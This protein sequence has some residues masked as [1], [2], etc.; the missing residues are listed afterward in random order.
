M[1]HRWDLSRGESH[2]VSWPGNPGAE[3]SGRL[4]FGTVR[5]LLFYHCAEQLTCW[6]AADDWKRQTFVAEKAGRP[7]VNPVNGRVAFCARGMLHLRDGRTLEPVRPPYRITDKKIT[8]IPDGQT[9][10]AIGASGRGYVAWLY[11]ADSG[12]TSQPLT[13]PGGEQNADTDEIITELACSPDGALLASASEWSRHVKLWDLAGYRLAADRI[14]GTSG[15]MRLAFRP[16]GHTLAVAADRTVSLFEVTG[17]DVHTALALQP[18]PVHT[19]AVGPDG[20]SLVCLATAVPERPYSNVTW[21]P[22]GLN[23]AAP[24]RSHS[25]NRVGGHRP[26]AA[27]DP[28]GRGIVY[29]TERGDA[30][31]VEFWAARG[32]PHF[33]FQPLD[34]VKQVRFG[35]DGSL[36]AAAGHEVLA[37]ALP[38]WRALARWANGPADR[39][40]GLVYCTVAPGRVWVLAGRRDGRV[41]LLDPAA[42]HHATWTVG[43]MLVS[44]LALDE[45]AGLAVAG[46]ES[47]LVK[48]FRVPSGEVAADIPLAHRDAVEAA[49][50][51]PGGQLFATGGRDRTI[52]LWQADGKPVL[53]F[54]A[55]AP[56]TML[57]FTPDGQ[58]LIALAAGERG[59]RRWRLGRLAERL[60]D[61]GIE[62]GFEAPVR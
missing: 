27:V 21:W 52:R 1:L 54:R 37:F 26:T 29:G 42:R 28:L 5:P 13:G 46:D 39:R 36:W 34:T 53:T 57:A 3:C 9:V 61:L 31:G 16:S 38:G 20:R 10:A 24:H 23:P 56:V 35:P 50:F 30:N 45:A 55:T 60:R 19:A 58:D 44:A 41:F 2:A 32:D 14:A 15:S 22:G 43:D 62:P 49:A 40:D 12:Q 18:F 25:A 6:D 4:A 7:A 48:V 33:E 11:D 17:Q 8:F 47:G 59:V 51:A